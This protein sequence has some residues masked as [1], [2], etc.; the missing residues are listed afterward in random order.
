VIFSSV[1]ALSLTPMMC[2]KVLTAGHG[3][4]RLSRAVDR[5]FTRTEDAYQRALARLLRAPWIAVAITGSLLAGCF[6]LART[7]PEEYAP[8]EDQGQIFV[9]AVAA[10][11][12]SVER[13]R[14]QL[15][16]LERPVM[17]LVDEGS[18]SRVMAR[19]PAF[20]SAS[21]S[22]GM[23]FITMAPQSERDLS[24]SDAISQLSEYW[25]RNPAVSVFAFSRSGLSRG[26]GDRPVQFVIGGPNYETLAQW[27]EIVIERASEHPAF[28]GL[29]TDLKETQPQ[30]IVRIDRNRAAALGV[31]NQN[32]GRTLAAMMNEQR[33]TTFVEDGEEYDVILQ[34]QDNQRA[35]SE[36]LQNIYVRSETT[37]ALIPLANLIYIDET[38]GPGALHRYNR[39]RALTVTAS[40][41]SGYALGE[42]L[43]VLEQ[44][45]R[46][47]LPETA[48]I[49]YKGESLEYQEASGSLYFTFGLAL[50][51]VF[52]VLA[53]QFESFVHPIVILLSVPLAIA[54]GL[55][56]LWVTGMT[57][58]IYSQIGM[59]M[60]IGIAAKNGVLLVE[61]INQLRDAGR[62]FDAAILEACRIRLRPVVMTTLATVMGSVPLIAAVGAGSESRQ[63]LGI[64]I[65]SGVSFA[66]LLTLF[67]VP[68]FYHLLARRTGSPSTIA[69]ALDEQLA[70]PE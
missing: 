9:R 35:S 58:N 44:I 26:G 23:L 55:I 66:T 61:F 59:I 70:L 14:A 15:E 50:L 43:A 32:I 38:A 41:N 4:N 64:V 57:L 56:G 42:A 2:S 10:E 49:D 48:Q 63:V 18:V 31:S 39:M 67:V 6:W 27:R 36:D 11:G 24:T 7:V 8:S 33:V 20:G 47:T 17:A 34:A 1:L 22:S 29:D 13:M 28:S 45:V 21:P 62:E 3:G 69:R 40:L 16:E 51:I 53:A 60:L 19:V 65:F 37:G 46:E 30:V 25:N 52:L 54:G 5:A 68:G 12:T